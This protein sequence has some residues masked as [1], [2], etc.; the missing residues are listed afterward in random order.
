M[1]WDQSLLNSYLREKCIS[2][3]L[4]HHF[5]FQG[6]GKQFENVHQL[7]QKCVPKC[8]IL[9]SGDASGKEPTCQCR[10]CKRCGFNP[11]VRTISW[12]RAWQPLQ[13]SCLE[14]PM[15]RGAWWAIVHG[16]RNSWRRLKQLRST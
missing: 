8:E 10:A 4:N 6:W 16:V 15:D 12:R 5:F 7:I 9:T 11:W 3:L 1:V 13:Y 14:N 2:I